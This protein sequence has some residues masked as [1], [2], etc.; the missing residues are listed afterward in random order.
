[1]LVL[2]AIPTDPPA[3]RNIDPHRAD[4][5]TAAATSGRFDFIRISLSK[6]M[7]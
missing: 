3:A 2:W 6:S 5:C 1:M 4:C 7:N